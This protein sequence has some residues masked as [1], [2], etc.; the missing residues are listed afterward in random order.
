MGICRCN[1]C[2]VT[3][4]DHRRRLVHR[5]KEILDVRLVSKHVHDVLAY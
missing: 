5:V 3:A 4:L 1:F 2:T